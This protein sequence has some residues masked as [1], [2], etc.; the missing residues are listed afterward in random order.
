MA[1][2]TPCEYWRGLLVLP[3]EQAIGRAR[4]STDLDT[5]QPALTTDADA[6]HLKR[7]W[8]SGVTDEVAQDRILSE[9]DRI[10]AVLSRQR[11]FSILKIDRTLTRAVRGREAYATIELIYV[12]ETSDQYS[13]RRTQWP[14][15]REPYAHLMR[16]PAAATQ[17]RTPVAR[18][19]PKP[20]TTGATEMVMRLFGQK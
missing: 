11:G 8:S 4:T 20:D 14:D 6:I 13:S 9:L 2:I 18:I 16:D 17:P 1:V 19:T 10:I 3:D 7:I 12:I 15:P 5:G